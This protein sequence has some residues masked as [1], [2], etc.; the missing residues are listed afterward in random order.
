MKAKFELILSKIL[1]CVWV[2]I[3]TI[4]SVTS[5]VAIIKLFLRVVGVM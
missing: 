5:L 1:G 3:F 4:A 2:A